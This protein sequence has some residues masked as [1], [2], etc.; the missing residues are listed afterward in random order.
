MQISCGGKDGNQVWAVNEANDIYYR[1]GVNGH[2]IH[3]HG[4]LK[5]ISVTGY[6]GQDV[7]GVR[8]D[9]KIYYRR[10]FKGSW[11]QV[12]GKLEQL[13]VGGGNFDGEFL[14]GINKG[15]TYFAYNS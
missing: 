13:S 15:K 1:N 2:W 10:G 3:V 7:W 4:K 8:A 11:T 6:K 14:W 5:Q 9:N 12:P